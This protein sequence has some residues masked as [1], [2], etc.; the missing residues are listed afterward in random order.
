MLCVPGYLGKHRGTQVFYPCSPFPILLWGTK[1]PL[2]KQTQVG[3][4]PGT[5]VFLNN[6]FPFPATLRN[7][8][9]KPITP[10]GRNQG[11]C[12]LFA[13]PPQSPV[14]CLQVL[15]PRDIWCPPRP[16]CMCDV[17]CCCAHFSVSST[18]CSFTLAHL[19]CRRS[20]KGSRPLWVSNRNRLSAQLLVT[21]AGS[22]LLLPS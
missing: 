8:S 19:G 17:N 2:T 21:E 6:K 7:H 15:S 3:W 22:Y 11:P 1:V 9:N 14:H 16:G 12:T 5:C 4:G 10:S 20:A 18:M 13:C